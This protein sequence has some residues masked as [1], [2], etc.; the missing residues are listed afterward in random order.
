MPAAL[1]PPPLCPRRGFVVLLRLSERAPPIVERRAVRNAVSQGDRVRQLF[2]GNAP[3]R[4]LQE[5]VGRSSGGGGLAAVL[6]C[7][8]ALVVF[9]ACRGHVADLVTAVGETVI[10]LHPPSNFSRCFN[11]DGEEMPAT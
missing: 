2:A 11:R 9:V 5:R 6:E 1:L 8:H 7:V 10:L 3:R 4:E